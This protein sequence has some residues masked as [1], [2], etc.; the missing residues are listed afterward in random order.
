[1]SLQTSPTHQRPRHDDTGASLI[2][3]IGFVVMVGAISAG[4][5]SLVTSSLNNRGTLEIVRNRQYAA[6]G[7]V[8][9]AVAQ[10]RLQGGTALTACASPGGTVVDTLN[11][12]AI[13]VDWRNVCAVVGSPRGGLVAQ[14]NVTFTA[15][16]NTPQP[17][18]EVDVIIRSQVNFEQASDGPVTKTYV[19]TWSVNR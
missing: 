10:V 4:L 9:E 7:A 19:Q 16:L 15:C 5:A 1:M 14:R 17:C 18:A 3:A 13:R 11:G 6:D 12:I 8:E 2:L